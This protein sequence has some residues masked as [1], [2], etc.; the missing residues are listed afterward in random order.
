MQRTNLFLHTGGQSVSFEDVCHV[1]TPK[2]EGVWH[3]IGHDILIE[4]IELGL[5]AANLGIVN[6][7]HSLAK[8]GKRYFGLYQVEAKDFEGRDYALVMGLRNSHDKMFPAGITVGSQVFVCD[9]LAFSGEIVL[10]RRHTTNIL[11]DL[12]AMVTKAIG[13]LGSMWNAQDKRFEAYKERTLTNEAAHDIMVNAVIAQALP[14]TSVPKVISEWHNPSHDEFSNRNVWRLY[15]AFTEA[16]KGNLNALPLR[17][18]SLHGILD[19]TCG[20][21]GKN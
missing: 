17:T 5:Q 9:N 18:R 12:P 20:L 21:I 19:A 6:R 11:K 8:D 13:D 10:G 2:P 4:Q 1:Q 7:Q 14:V 16:L 3:P 15:N